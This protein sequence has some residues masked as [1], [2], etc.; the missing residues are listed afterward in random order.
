MKLI[1]PLR[2]IKEH[3]TISRIAHGKYRV[4]VNIHNKFFYTNITS[5]Q[6]AYER[7]IFHDYLPASAKTSSG[8]TIK[9]AYHSIMSDIQIIQ[10]NNFYREIKLK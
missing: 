8:L 1:A 3:T 10:L 2:F 4:V 5:Y 9:Q 6:Q 7:I